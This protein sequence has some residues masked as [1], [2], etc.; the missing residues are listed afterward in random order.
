MSDCDTTHH[1]PETDRTAAGP[2]R[3]FVVDDHAG[4]RAVAAAVIE[5]TPGFVLVGSSASADEAIAAVLAVDPVPDLI[6]MDLNLGERS[7]VEVAEA[8][9]RA[10]PK[11]SII[12]VSTLAADELPPGVRDCGASGYF[13]KVTLC[14]AVLEHA[15]AG[16]YDWRP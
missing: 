8:L 15:R 2:T 14:P 12:L 1:G 3:V 13:P 4:Y 5:A 9:T 11:M 6:L 7:G 16:A 10:G